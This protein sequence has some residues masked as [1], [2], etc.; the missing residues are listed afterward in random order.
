MPF[1]LTCLL[2]FQLDSFLLVHLNGRPDHIEVNL[3][4][5]LPPPTLVTMPDNLVYMH[6]GD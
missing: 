2:T 5:T 1:S 4:N 6:L 3:K